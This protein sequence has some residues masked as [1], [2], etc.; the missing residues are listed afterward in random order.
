MVREARI[1]KASHWG[2][3]REEGAPMI[4]ILPFFGLWCHNTMLVIPVD[5]SV[6]VSYQ[7]F[8]TPLYQ[9]GMVFVILSYQF[10]TSLA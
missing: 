4:Y 7:L 6:H 3:L 2:T 9:V 8:I 1:N 5:T 10:S